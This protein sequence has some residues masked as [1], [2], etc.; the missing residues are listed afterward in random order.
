MTLTVKELIMVLESFD[1]DLPILIGADGVTW[2]ITSTSSIFIQ[3]IKG[4]KNIVI[5]DGYWNK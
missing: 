5:W 2:D 1:E 4:E 3:E